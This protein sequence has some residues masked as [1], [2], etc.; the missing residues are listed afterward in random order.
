MAG[1]TKDELG[2]IGGADHLQ[3]TTAR[4]DGSL[5]SPVTV[6]VARQGE[7]LYV[8]SWCG[9][10][11]SWFCAVQSRNEGHIRAGGVDRDVWFVEAADESGDAIDASY[12]TKYHRYSERYLGPMIR[13]E[14]RATTLRLVPR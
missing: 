12:R 9:R 6:W 8:R 2:T 4:S 13:P 11:S 1:W 10:G 5:R 7:G 14:A 3:L